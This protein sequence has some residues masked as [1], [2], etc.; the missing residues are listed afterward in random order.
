MSKIAVNEIT[1]EAGTGSPSFTNGLAQSDISDALNASGSAPLYACRAWVNFDGTDGSIRDSGNVS[2]V[3][4][5]GT[6]DY[7]VNF[8]TAMPDGD[9]SVSG[10]A[11]NRNTNGSRGTNGIMT[12]NGNPPSSSSCRVLT[13]YGSTSTSDGALQNV[14]YCYVSI[15]R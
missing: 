15:F 8:A 12:D 9:Y 7:T 6:G 11:G 13:A 5:N 4:K 14:D 10:T 3:T 2:S 1:D